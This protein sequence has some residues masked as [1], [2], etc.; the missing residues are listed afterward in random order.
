M[1]KKQAKR[2]T[3]K[4]S[5]KK[6]AT[7][8]ST[9]L[10]RQ[11]APSFSLIDPK[12]LMPQPPL[13][14]SRQIG[15]GISLL[16]ELGLVEGKFTKDEIA[17][18]NRPIDEGRIKWKPGKKGPDIPY[19]SHIDYTRWF[20]EAFGHGAWNLVPSDLPKL[21]K[22]TVSREYV[23]FVHGR[24]I[25][26]AVGEQ[27]YF[28][29]N[30][31]QTY[32]DA[33]ESTMSSALRRCAKH[34]GF[35]LELWDKD[36]MDALRVKAGKGGRRQP[37]GDRESRT[38]PPPAQSRH[39]HQAAPISEPQ[40]TRML[41]IINKAGRTKSEVLAYLGAFYKIDKWENVKT[42]TR[43]VYD[44]VC[45]AIEKRGPLPVKPDKD[46]QVREP[47]AILDA[48]DIQWGNVPDGDR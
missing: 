12:G 32:G 7:A 11:A 23:L 45:T 6:K 47:D 4:K 38:T 44:V 5:A 17:V 41:A 3:K 27:D 31:Q 15:Q 40:Y 29:N 14:V 25:A 22:G 46:T 2:A 36:Y 39:A 35:G 24:P 1:A 18:I 19:L 43:D 26:F 21:T 33:L 34:L 48:D 20:N 8:A 9:A 13:S 28:E 10:V 42:L 37:E 16:G 30:P